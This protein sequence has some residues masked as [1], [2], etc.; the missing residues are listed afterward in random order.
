MRIFQENILSLHEKID[1]CQKKIS[2]K[3]KLLKK[4]IDR[5]FLEEWCSKNKYDLRCTGCCWRFLTQEREYRTVMGASN[6]RVTFGESKEYLLCYIDKGRVH[7]QYRFVD[8]NP[9]QSKSPTLS[10]GGK[11]CKFSRDLS[12]T[13]GIKEA[14]VKI[15]SSIAFNVLKTKDIN[16]TAVS[17]YDAA[18]LEYFRVANDKSSLKGNYES[19]VTVANVELEESTDSENEGESKKFVQQKKLKE[20]MSVLLILLISLLLCFVCILFMTQL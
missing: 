14:G 13:S 5:N 11:I 19:Q 7:G 12:S 4:A 1:D 9:D 15:V 18:V 2:K 17:Y 6:D 3:Q 20:V 16:G 10:S 8:E